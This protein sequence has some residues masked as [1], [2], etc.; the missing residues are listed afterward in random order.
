MVHFGLD[1]VTEHDLVDHLAD[2]RLPFLV[3]HRRHDFAT[4]ALRFGRGDGLVRSD[5]GRI[6]VHLSLPSPA[7]LYQHSSTGRQDQLA[8]LALVGVAFL[9][10]EFISRPEVVSP[11]C[12][13]EPGCGLDLKI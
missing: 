5:H 13:L 3:L 1:S 6:T 12:I 7:V 9:L 4:L 10:N 8:N 2:D 11:R